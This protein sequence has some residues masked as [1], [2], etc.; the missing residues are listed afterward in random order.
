MRNFI[1]EIEGLVNVYEDNGVLLASMLRWPWIVFCEHVVQYLMDQSRKIEID[2]V[3]EK[4]FI[5]HNPRPCIDRWMS[6]QEGI[7]F[8]KSIIPSERN[9]YRFCAVKKSTFDKVVAIWFNN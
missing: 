8:I 3:F 1:S 6:C 2:E 9:L 5:F 7:E 4:C